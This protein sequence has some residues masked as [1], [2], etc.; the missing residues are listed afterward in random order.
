MMSYRLVAIEFDLSICHG[1]NSNTRG[2]SEN[3]TNSHAKI[4]NFK[5]NYVPG[6]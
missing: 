4:R 5:G 3:N 1:I 6:L 2:S